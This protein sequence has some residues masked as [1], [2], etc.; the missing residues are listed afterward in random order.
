MAVEAKRGCGYRKC[1]GLY[2]V[3]GGVG[4]PCDR[5]PIQ[6]SVCPVCSHGFKQARGWT[7]VDINGLVGGVHRDCKDKFPCPLCMATSEMGKCGLIWTGERF[8]KTP[9]DFDREGAELGISR[10]IKAVPRGFKVGETWVLLAHPKTVRDMTLC[11]CGH[12]AEAHK[13]YEGVPMGCKPE[14]EL[15]DCGSF[16]ASMQPGIF[17]VWRPERIE[18][19]LPESMRDS[20]EVKKLIEDGLTPVFFPDDDPDHRGTVYD[21]PDEED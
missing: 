20:E 4:H 8:Y 3:G 17:K 2:L 11:E 13:R 1:G 12:A 5:L 21:K 6:L 7:W 9:G 16:Q 10:R 15:C 14:G 19:C 18:K